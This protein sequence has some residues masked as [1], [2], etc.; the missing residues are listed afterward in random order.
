MTKLNSKMISIQKIIEQK[1]ESNQ[2]GSI[3]FPNDFVQLG[4]E[5]AIRQA[6]SRLVKEKKLIRLAQG[7][8]LYPEIDSEFGVIYPSME[9]IAKAIARRD[10]MRIIPTGVY[11]LNRLGLST[12]VPLKALYLTDGTPRTI[13]IGNRTIDF[14][15]TS[16]KILD[17]KNELL[18]LLVTA[19][20]TLGKEN[21]TS[22][23][24]SKIN[25]IIAFDTENNI[26]DELYKAPTWIGKLIKTYQNKTYDN[27]MVEYNR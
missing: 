12:Q 2:K 1:L 21:I 27:G 5:E 10:K 13:K 22:E 25:E 18:V 9:S 17:I 26:F 11:A 20:Q 19:L 7:I 14:Q 6:L 3:V 8:Y 24:K 23:I 15:R 4:S 16:P